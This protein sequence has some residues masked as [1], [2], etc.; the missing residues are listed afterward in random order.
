MSCE[1]YCVITSDS[2]ITC[3]ANEQ[4][5]K[6]GT[7]PLVKDEKEELVVTASRVCRART[8]PA[9]QAPA[10][11]PCEAAPVLLAPKAVTC[12]V[13]SDSRRTL[14]SIELAWYQ[15][16]SFAQPHASRSAPSD[17]TGAGGGQFQTSSR[18]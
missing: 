1:N 13:C 3:Y 15:W 12:W 6:F 10:H 18:E 8:D 7:G 11:L 16:S 14:N 5:A 17:T 9:P 4:K 2:V